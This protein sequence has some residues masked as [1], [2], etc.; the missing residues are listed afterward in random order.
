MRGAQMRWD[1]KS[2]RETKRL[3]IQRPHCSYKRQQ[4]F[5]YNL[6]YYLMPMNQHHFL[7]CTNSGVTHWWLC[8][9][10]S[11]RRGGPTDWRSL[12]RSYYALL[13]CSPTVL[14]YC[15]LCY[16]LYYPLSYLRSILPPLSYD[17]SL[18]LVYL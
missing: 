3:I 16:A 7:T 2:R 6:F 17:Y 18:L 14:S 9:Q 11:G 1:N 15:A 5:N 4:S 12:L 10:A 13:L 8:C